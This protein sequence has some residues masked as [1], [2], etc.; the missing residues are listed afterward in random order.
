MIHKD[1]D[2]DRFT[3]WTQLAIYGRHNGSRYEEYHFTLFEQEVVGD[4]AQWALSKYGIS[5][6]HMVLH[7]EQYVRM[8]WEDKLNV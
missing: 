1:F 8:Y 2:V 6:H 4:I 3:R 7:W 5:Y